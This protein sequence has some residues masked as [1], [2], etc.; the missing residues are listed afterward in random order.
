[1]NNIKRSARLMLS[2]GWGWLV[3]YGRNR[4][5]FAGKPRTSRIPRRLPSALNEW[6]K[7]TTRLQHMCW[8]LIKRTLH[9]IWQMAYAWADRLKLFSLSRVGR[10]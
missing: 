9:F 10:T 6:Y 1:M 2:T 7:A 4:Q 3:K 8:K 5:Q